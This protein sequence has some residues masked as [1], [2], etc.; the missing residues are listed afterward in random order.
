MKLWHSIVI[1]IS[2]I[3]GFVAHAGIKAYSEHERTQ[4]SYELQIRML[5]MRPVE[6]SIGGA[7]VLYLPKISYRDLSIDVNYE[8]YT[9]SDGALKK[10]TLSAP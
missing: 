4:R 3:I 7:N 5:E 6:L 2:I 8:F 10:L 9:Y 1:G